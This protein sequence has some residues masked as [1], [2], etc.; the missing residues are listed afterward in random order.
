LTIPKLD[1]PLRPIFIHPGT[2]CPPTVP[3]PRKTSKPEYIPIICL[4]ASTFIPHGGPETVRDSY[5]AFEYV[6][7]SGDDDELWGKGLKPGHFFENRETLLGTAKEELPGVVERIL[8]GLGNGGPAAMKGLE[9]WVQVPHGS[10]IW[11]GTTGSSDLPGLERGYG[12]ITFIRSDSPGLELG[13]IEGSSPV[14]EELVIRLREGK[15]KKSDLGFST[16]VLPPVVEFADRMRAQG[17]DVLVRDWDGKSL[18]VGVAVVLC[19][20]W[21]GDD[22]AP[23]SDLESRVVG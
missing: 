14:T 17:K 22:G 1:R 16:Q 6:Q 15:R 5:G 18:S 21:I 2:T 11:L 13:R 10:G 12:V 8:W 9:S 4:S 3:L 19:W 20:R 23:R 7:G